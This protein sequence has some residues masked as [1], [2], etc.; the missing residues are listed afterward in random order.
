MRSTSGPGR[1]ASDKGRTAVLAR[2]GALGVA[3]NAGRAPL[4]GRIVTGDHCTGDREDDQRRAG[5]EPPTTPEHPRCTERDTRQ[6]Q[7]ERTQQEH[8]AQPF[9]VGGGPPVA[10]VDSREGEGERLPE[11]VA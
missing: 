1:S 4:A 7:E 3:S 9:L 11:Y 8:A 10:H 5:D 2:R 6:P